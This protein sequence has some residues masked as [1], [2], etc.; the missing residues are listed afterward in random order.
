VNTQAPTI[1]DEIAKDFSDNKRHLTDAEQRRLAGMIDELLA[2]R[3]PA[4]ADAAP[5]GTDGWDEVEA[6]RQAIAPVIDWYQ[7]DE[8]HPRLTVDIVKDAVADLQSDREACL[9]LTSA[10]TFAATEI[11]AWMGN[12]NADAIDRMRGDFVRVAERL[13]TA[14]KDGAK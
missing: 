6:V 11:R 2:Q 3:A 14:L 5:T 4:V 8:E 12:W 10:A 13:E 1:G 7:P 9:R